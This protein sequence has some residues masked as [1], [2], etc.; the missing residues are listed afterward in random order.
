MTAREVR[1]GAIRR[2]QT[3][4]NAL[5]AAA[6][7]LHNYDT[8]GVQSTRPSR[9]ATLTVFSGTHI[10]HSVSKL[11]VILVITTRLLCASV[12]YALFL[13]QEVSVVNVL[14]VV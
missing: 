11:H 5:A 3:I 7:V 6:G 8:D 14:G 4:S 9:T 12:C 13:V 1:L 2:Q 10:L